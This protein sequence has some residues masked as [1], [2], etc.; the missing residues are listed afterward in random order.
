[1]PK[2]PTRCNII[3]IDMLRPSV[4]R[5]KLRRGDRRRE[6]RYIC[7]ERLFV[8]VRD[9]TARPD[10]I[11]RTLPGWTVDI[12]AHGLKLLCSDALPEGARVDLWVEISGVPGKFYLSAVV[13]WSG[14][15]ESGKHAV[16]LR[17]DGQGAG[18]DAPAWGRLFGISGP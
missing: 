3:S 14:L 17:I 18:T 6:P 15:A 4:E 2:H 1:M 7:Q 13:R 11:G 16:G 5:H 12:S 10:L 8:Q 9:C